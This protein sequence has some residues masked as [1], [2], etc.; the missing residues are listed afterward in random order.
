MKSL[1]IILTLLTTSLYSEAKIYFGL[2]YG[3]FN[4]DFSNIAAKSSSESVRLKLG[5]GIRENYSIEFALEAL[6]NDSKIFS[7]NDG[8]KYALNIALVKTFDFDIYVLPFIKLGFG[9]GYM[10]VNRELQS[11]LNFGSFNAEVGTYIPINEYLDFEIAYNYKDLSYEAV[12]T[13]AYELKYKSNVDTFYF[14]FNIRY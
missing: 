4:E 10:D 12:D 7:N 11:K 13:I 9:A 1:I 5:Y 3:K 2:D 6:D 14:G 8:E